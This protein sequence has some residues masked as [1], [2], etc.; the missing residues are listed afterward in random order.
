MS[1]LPVL[2]AWIWISVGASVAGWLLSGLGMLNRAG[3]L[4]FLAAAAVIFVVGRKI[5]GCQPGMT[6][7]NWPKTRKRFSRWLPLGFAALTLLVFL[8]GALYPP[9]NHAAF[10]YRTPRVLHWLAEGQWHWIHTAN[11]RMNNRACGSLSG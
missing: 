1:F 6:A 5:Y 9:T 8:G 7:F 3:Y 11:Y 4:I 10:T 2:R